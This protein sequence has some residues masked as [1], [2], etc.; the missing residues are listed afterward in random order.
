MC[1]K[2]KLIPWWEN[3]IRYIIMMTIII[4]VIVIISYGVTIITFDHELLTK[5]NTTPS[6]YEID[7]IFGMIPYWIFISMPVVL[8]AILY[9]TLFFFFNQNIYVVPK[10]FLFE[11]EMKENLI[12]FIN[13][14]PIVFL[15]KKDSDKIEWKENSKIDK[16]IYITSSCFQNYI[17]CH[18]ENGGE[19]LVRQYVFIKNISDIVKDGSLKGTWVWK[20]H[21]NEF[22][23][24]VLIKLLK[25]VH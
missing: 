7:S 12:P 21:H 8:I 2:T 4:G 10:R 22:V 13:N 9:Y 3:L 1:L 20:W 18:D 14:K 24:L 25:S 19:F 15:K 6:T 17:L 5:E 16:K 23:E 11:H